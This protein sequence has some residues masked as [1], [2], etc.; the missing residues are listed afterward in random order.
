MRI[1]NCEGL[2]AFIFFGLFYP[3][4]LTIIPTVSVDSGGYYIHQKPPPLRELFF[5]FIIVK[6]IYLKRNLNII[7]VHG[8]AV[9]FSAVA[10]PVV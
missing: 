3:A 5:K 2:S 1:Q 6:I 4:T 8:F 10:L 9:I 7:F